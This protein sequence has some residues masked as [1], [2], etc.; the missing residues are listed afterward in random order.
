MRAFSAFSGTRPM[1]QQLGASANRPIR[2]SSSRRAVV[3][4]ARQAEAGVG[5][6]GTK[7]G[8][9]TYFTSDGLAV[10]ATVIALEEG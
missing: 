2:A 1:K 9:M 8:M 10:P 7:A 3:V 4:Q 6:F 5:I